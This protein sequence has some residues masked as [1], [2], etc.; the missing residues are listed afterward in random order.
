MGVND[1]SGG[2]GRL[3]MRGENTEM[4]VFKNTVQYGIDINFYAPLWNMFAM[5]A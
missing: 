2:G 1:F 4:T 5:Y 3:S